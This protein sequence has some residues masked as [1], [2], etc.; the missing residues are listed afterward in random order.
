MCIYNIY[1]H[2]YKLSTCIYSVYTVYVQVYIYVYL[3]ISLV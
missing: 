1:I 3:R 2:L